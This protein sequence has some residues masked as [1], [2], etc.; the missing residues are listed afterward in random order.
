MQSNLPSPRSAFGIMGLV[1]ATF[2]VSALATR[3]FF[4]TGSR[5]QSSLPNNLE[6]ENTPKQEA[7]VELT[8]SS[9]LEASEQEA[10]VELT[11]SSI[12]EEAYEAIALATAPEENAPVT[13]ETAAPEQTVEPTVQ[14]TAQTKVRSTI[15]S[16][17]SELETA[18]A[19]EQEQAA[20]AAANTRQARA[21]AAVSRF[22]AKVKSTVEAVQ[23]FFK[24][25][26]ASL[27]NLG[28]DLQSVAV[29]TGSS[30]K[31]NSN[32]IVASVSSF[33][34]NAKSAFMNVISKVKAAFTK[35]ATTNAETATSVE[36]NV[37]PVNEIVASGNDITAPTAPAMTFSYASSDD[38]AAAI[39]K[40][41]PA[42]NDSTP[43]VEEKAS[44]RR[45]SFAV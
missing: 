17:L 30:I 26:K 13:T 5:S 38:L 28:K 36:V 4:N 44:S 3:F 1:A 31:T 18:Q 19:D 10:T 27:V 15:K 42:A 41:T 24:I 21:R 40:A 33:F 35:P 20:E 22:A 9:V 37:T 32:S 8:P 39:S 7:T 12:V 14:E 29:K 11:P 43:T 23:N 16:M 34:A 45:N 6:T 25:I 2:G